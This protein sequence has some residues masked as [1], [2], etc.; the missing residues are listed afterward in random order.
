MNLGH[1]AEQNQPA[2]L[3]GS[4]AGR[5]EGRT[6]SGERLEAKRD[7]VWLPRTLVK[8]TVTPKGSGLLLLITRCQ[9]ADV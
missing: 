8:E 6:L 7:R 1:N 9:R 5:G 3:V 2:P 4:V